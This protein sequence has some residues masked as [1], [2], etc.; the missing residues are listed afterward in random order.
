L[1][2]CTLGRT[3]HTRSTVCCASLSANTTRGRAARCA[4]TRTPSRRPTPPSRGTHDNSPS[5]T[6]FGR[7]S[8]LLAL[9]FLSFLYFDPALGLSVSQSLVLSFFLSF[10]GAASTTQKN[11]PAKTKT[12]KTK[13]QKNKKKQ[14]KQKKTKKTKKTKK[15]KNDWLATKKTF[16][17]GRKDTGDKCRF[18][19]MFLSSFLED[20]ST[21][22]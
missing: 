17:C 21:L 19:R 9:F 18:R 4:G 5:K 15:S 3:R 2:P 7:L 12:K 22:R 11:K 16:T 10:I 13:K 1:R 6:F 20:T 14:K 8:F